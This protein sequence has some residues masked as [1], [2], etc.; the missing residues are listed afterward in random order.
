MLAA[1]GI[2]SLAPAFLIAMAA[3]IVVSLITKINGAKVN[4]LF[5][6]ASKTEI[7]GKEA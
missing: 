7:G 1:T 5:A 2:Y 6:K 3:V 4:E